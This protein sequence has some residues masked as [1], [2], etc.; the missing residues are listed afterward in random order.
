MNNHDRKE[1]EVFLEHGVF[2]VVSRG[3]SILAKLDAIT[4]QIADLKAND[5][6]DDGEVSVINDPVLILGFDLLR[7]G[8]RD[9]W[10]SDDDIDNPDSIF[11]PHRLAGDCRA[12]PYLDLLKSVTEKYIEVARAKELSRCDAGG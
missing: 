8:V 10:C 9:L 1:F 2:L 11:A 6:D 4:E 7:S 5:P 12:F 3:G